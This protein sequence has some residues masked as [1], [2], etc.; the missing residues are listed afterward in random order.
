MRL[1]W[2]AAMWVT[3]VGATSLAA[4]PP[5]NNHVY[6]PEPAWDEFRRVAEAEIASQLIDPQSAQFAWAGGIYKGELKIILGPRTQG[7]VGCGTVNA[8]NRMGGYVG[9]TPFAVVI[10]YGRVLFS[11]LDRTVGVECSMLQSAGKFPPVPASDEAV[12]TGPANITGLAL[13]SMP[14]GAYV[15]TVTPGSAAAAAGLKPGMVIVSVNGVPLAGMD[16]SMLKV[17]EAAGQTAILTAV[18]GSTFK[19]GAKP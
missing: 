5:E 4:A 17:I 2:I 8:R 14:D 18:G 7:Y 10:D 6:G 15:S 3:A 1:P 13:R 12:S 19:L 9:A 16:E 11:Q